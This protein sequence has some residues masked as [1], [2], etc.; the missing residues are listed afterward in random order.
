MILGGP[1]YV[2]CFTCIQEGSVSFSACL[3]R[4]PRRFHFKNKTNTFTTSHYKNVKKLLTTFNKSSFPSLSSTFSHS[5]PLRNDSAFPEKISE[6]GGRKKNSRGCAGET[7]SRSMTFALSEDEPSLTLPDK[8]GSCSQHRGGSGTHLAT[9][10]YTLYCLHISTR[11]S[12]GH[13][14]HSSGV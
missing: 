6:L 11:H 8:P 3:H 1:L 5:L 9:H 14:P 7:A 4:I 13:G 10:I 2:H 12:W